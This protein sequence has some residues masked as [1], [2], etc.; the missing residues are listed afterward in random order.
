[1]EKCIIEETGGQQRLE[2]LWMNKLQS[3]RAT[4][5]SKTQNKGILAGTYGTRMSCHVHIKESLSQNH[6]NSRGDVAL[7]V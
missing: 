2:E 3:R 1:M 6:Q 5:A 4:K 7:L